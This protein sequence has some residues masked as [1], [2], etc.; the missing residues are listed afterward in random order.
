[1]QAPVRGDLRRTGCALRWKR[2]RRQDRGPRRSPVGLRPF[3]L[4][5]AMLPVLN[6]C[7]SCSRKTHILSQG[8]HVFSC[9]RGMGCGGA[10]G[11]GGRAEGRL[12]RSPVSHFTNIHSRAHSAGCYLTQTRGEAFALGAE[13][14]TFQLLFRPP[15]HRHRDLRGREAKTCPWPQAF[16]PSPFCPAMEHG[17][18][19]RHR[20]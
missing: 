8:G 17:G 20:R 1:M 16:P 10:E 12:N 4:P 15:L 2:C 6:Q 18:T 11:A 7:L 5:P 14:H 9:C 3:L 19:W 13:G